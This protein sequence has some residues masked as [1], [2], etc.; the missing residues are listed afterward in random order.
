[1]PVNQPVNRAI[2]SQTP[3]IWNGLRPARPTP[4]CVVNFCSAF[5]HPTTAAIMHRQHRPLRLQNEIKYAN[6]QW[7][8]LVLH[9]EFFITRHSQNN[10]NHEQGF[11]CFPFDLY[12]PRN[13]YV[14]AV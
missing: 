2:T 13:W 5:S 4:E 14:S 8:F 6:F 3:L 9:K 1:V 10:F 11:Y 7:V 12:C